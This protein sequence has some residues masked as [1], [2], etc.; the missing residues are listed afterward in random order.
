MLATHSHTDGD[1]L[2]SMLALYDLLLQMG[3]QAVPIAKGGVPVSL[4]FLPSQSTV[5]EDVPHD[6]LD[7]DALV[8][9]GCYEPHRTDIAWIASSKLPTLNFDHHHDNSRYGEVAL[10]DENKSAVAEVVYD[11]FVAEIFRR[12]CGGRAVS[13]HWPARGHRLVHA[14]QHEGIHAGSCWPA[15]AQRCAS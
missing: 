4:R 9:F 15:H 13:A 3:K 12:Q 8:L 10:V 11:F 2:G 14:R 1:D 6:F 5:A 7:A